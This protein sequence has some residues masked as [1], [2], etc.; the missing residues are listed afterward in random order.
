VESLVL[1]VLELHSF[2]YFVIARDSCRERELHRL[3]YRVMFR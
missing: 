2:Q 1:H 3:G